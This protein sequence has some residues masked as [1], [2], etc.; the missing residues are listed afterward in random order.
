MVVAS[1]AI[2]LPTTRVS[3]RKP[4]LPWSEIPSKTALPVEPSVGAGGIGS[5]R[6]GR[7]FAA[8]VLAGPSTFL[9][10]ATTLVGAFC[11]TGFCVTG[12]AV[13]D[14]AGGSAGAP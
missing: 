6:T 1:A 8:S 4:R 2:P 7:G 12:F 5:E 13:A 10:A 11:V 3:R 9:A 14:E